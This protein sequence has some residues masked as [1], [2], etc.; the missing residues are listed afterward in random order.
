[1]VNEWEAE[2]IP[3]LEASQL[4]NVRVEEWASIKLNEKA[5]N[6]FLALRETRVAG[7][8]AIR[9]LQRSLSGPGDS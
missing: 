6:M 2:N 1:M 3:G 9:R 7:G 5:A 4:V 8:E